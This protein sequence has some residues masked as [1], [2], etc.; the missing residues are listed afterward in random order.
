VLGKEHAAGSM[1]L[2]LTT[3]LAI[4]AIVLS[5]F[6]TVAAWA[7]LGLLTVGFL[8]IL[9]VVRKRTYPYFQELSPRANLLI[10]NHGHYYFMPF[11]GTDCS[12]ACSA[13]GLA[14]LSVIVISCFRGD[15]WSIV[16]G[17]V[18]NVAVFNASKSFNPTNFLSIL[19]RPYHDEIIAWARQKDKERHQVQSQEPAKK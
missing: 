4:S 5:F 18:I 10:R 9:F 3:L 8:L 14:S 11:A 1:A 2:V 13:I 16:V 19:E 17:G 6:S 15:W 12:G 7:L